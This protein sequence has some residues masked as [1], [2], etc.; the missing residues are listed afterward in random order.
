MALAD[1]RERDVDDLLGELRGIL[2][3]RSDTYDTP[4]GNLRRMA[5]EMTPTLG[6]VPSRWEVCDLMIGV[7]RAR[8]RFQP[9]RDNP[10]D[11]AGWAL[12]YLL[13]EREAARR[14]E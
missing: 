6:R 5:E 12:C 8:Q 11:I 2:L 1:H 4:F 9:H 14:D 7:K 3:A 10:L 13:A